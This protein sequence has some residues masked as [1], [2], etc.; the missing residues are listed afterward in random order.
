MS[1]EKQWW[2]PVLCDAKW[3]EEIRKDYPEK[4]DMDDDELKDYFN[5]DRKYQITWD[6]VGDAYEQYEKLAD[7]YLILKQA[8]K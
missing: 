6:H 2:E 5:D 1:E 7:A 8:S 4:S 3:V